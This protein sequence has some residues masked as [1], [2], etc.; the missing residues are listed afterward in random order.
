[1]RNSAARK[2]GGRR[3]GRPASPDD[4]S[5]PVRDCWCRPAGL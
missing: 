4:R 1:M 5:G 3:S 2:G